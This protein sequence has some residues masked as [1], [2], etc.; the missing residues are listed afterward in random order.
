MMEPIYRGSTSKCIVH[1]KDS[2]QNNHRKQRQII[3]SFIGVGDETV[4]RWFKEGTLPGGAALVRLRYY[5]E[6]LG[7]GVEELRVMPPALR[8][9][10]RL[11]AFR[12]ADLPEIVQLVGYTEGSNGNDTVL[13]V[14]KGLRRASRH[15]L[16]QFAAFVELYKDRLLD[17]QQATTKLKLHAPE[18]MEKVEE[19]P[20]IPQVVAVVHPQRPEMQRVTQSN[21][22]ILKSVAGQIMAMLPLVQLVSSDAFTAEE[23]AQLREL[24]GGD[25]VF[26]FANLLFRLCGERSRS[27]HSEK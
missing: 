15:K 27:M 1:L 9:A 19:K 3:A 25:G 21:D 18:A 5:L 10:G 13:A 20:A 16:L 11:F 26:K 7:Y 12:V 22:V 8:D 6:F 17:K 4:N 23:R 24:T 14:F 2:I